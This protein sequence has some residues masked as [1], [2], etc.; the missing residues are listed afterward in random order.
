VEE[1]CGWQFFVPAA[2]LPCTPPA[3]TPR[4]GTHWLPAICAGRTLPPHSSVP[5]TLAR[6]LTVAATHP[7]VHQVLRLDSA[8]EFSRPVDLAAFPDYSEEVQQPMD[9]GTVKVRGCW[10]A[11][12]LGPSGGCTAAQQAALGGL[13]TQ[14]RSRQRADGRVSTSCSSTGCHTARTHMAS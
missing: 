11:G 9:L 12:W 13:T 14:C 8:A 2:R 4:H 7:A 10:L 3:C 6:Q 5:S 1:C